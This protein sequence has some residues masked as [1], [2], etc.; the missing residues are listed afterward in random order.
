MNKS[1]EHINPIS[2]SQRE[3]ALLEQIELLRVP[4]PDWGLDEPENTYIRY[5]ELQRKGCGYS[6]IYI[7]GNFHGSMGKCRINQD[8]RCLKKQ[9]ND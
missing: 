1:F 7:N 8:P 5:C 6:E 9:S 2:H 3:S 4:N